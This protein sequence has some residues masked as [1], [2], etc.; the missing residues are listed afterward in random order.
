MADT[1]EGRRTTY[2]EVLGEPKFRVLF[3]SRSLTI[4]ADTLRTVALST[5]IFQATGSAA[6]AALVFGIS[7]LPQLVGG[8]F[9]GAL[10]DRYSPRMII[11]ASYLLWTVVTA[12]L[13]LA[14]LST[15]ACLALVGI[16]ACGTP[17]Q[18]GASSKL[19]A[20]TLKGDAYV[21][22][23]SLWTVAGSV[24]QLLG[25]AGGG[26]AVAVVSPR[27]ALLFTA[28][29]Y[30]VAALMVWIGLRD[31]P[32][33]PK[34]EAASASVMSQSWRGNR[35]L[36]KNREVRVLL[37]AQ[38]LPPAFVTGA[39]SLLIPYAAMRDFPA[40][41]A[42]FLLACVPAGML[43]GNLIVGRLLRPAHRERLTVHLMLACGVPLLPLALDLPLV[44]IGALL[45]VVGFGFAYG[46]GI[47]RQF[48]TATP[49]PLR[50]QAFGLLQTVVMTLQ[51]LGPVV[52]GA[53]TLLFSTGLSMAVAGALTCLTALLYQVVRL[54]GMDSSRPEANPGDHVTA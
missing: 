47:Q 22:G 5:L 35:E 31:L 40:G 38:C 32:K 51:G 37:L 26:I 41:S 36:L 25:M 50:G 48:L 1:P 13:G 2:R 16:V 49:V 7:F 10:A 19:V 4:G 17:I 8:V 14:Q 33:S 30:T 11:V 23:R 20:E 42:G 28:V 34:P 53:L 54:R 3:A 21:V 15:A 12:T 6:L 18:A 27:G 44:A 45:L 52:L 43:L 24:A 39:T 9:L 46:L 29:C